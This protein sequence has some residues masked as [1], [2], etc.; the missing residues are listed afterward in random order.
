MKKPF[1]NLK[2]DDISNEY[3]KRNVQQ[4]SLHLVTI[5]MLGKERLCVVQIIENVEIEH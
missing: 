3:E 5:E 2:Y 4:G 1:R